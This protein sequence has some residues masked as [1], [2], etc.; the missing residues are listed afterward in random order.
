MGASRDYVWRASGN[1]VDLLGMELTLLSAWVS[2]TDASDLQA[3]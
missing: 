2:T 3:S 1:T